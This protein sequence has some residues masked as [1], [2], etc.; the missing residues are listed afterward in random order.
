M[1]YQVLTV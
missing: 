1:Q